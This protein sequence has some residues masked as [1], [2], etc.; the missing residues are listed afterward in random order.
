MIE[1]QINQLRIRRHKSIK[2]ELNH[3]KISNKFNLDRY[4]YGFKKGYEQGY[5]KAKKE[6]FDD[7]DKSI[8]NG[9]FVSRLGN[10][11]E[12]VINR[13]KRKHYNISL[14]SPNTD[15]KNKEDENNG[16]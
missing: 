11:A 10:S 4:D 8:E 13:L 14:R 12:Y 3:Q 15:S 16:N 7:I 5:N 1:F 2:M 9:E 6:F